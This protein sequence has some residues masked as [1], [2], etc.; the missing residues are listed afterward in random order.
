MHPDDREEAI[1]LHEEIQAA[2]QSGNGQ[3]LE[4]A[5]KALRELLF[6]IEGKS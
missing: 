5:S 4:R 6:F 1:G 3:G 2:V